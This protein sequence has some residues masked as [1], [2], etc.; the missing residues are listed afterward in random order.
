MDQQ[1]KRLYQ[2]FRAVASR[3]EAGAL[4]AISEARRTVAPE[5]YSEVMRVLGTIVPR[6]KAIFHRRPSLYRD[7]LYSP[8]FNPLTLLKELAW[9]EVWLRGA[10]S[11]LN[12]FL[13][14]Q[15][16][17]QRLFAAG[18]LDRMS[19]TIEDFIKEHGWSFWAVELKYALLQQLKGTEAL[20]QMSLQLQFAA[21]NRASALF[22][23]ILTDRNDA[24]F[25]FD[26]FQ[27]KCAKSTPNFSQPWVRAYVPYRAL[28]SVGDPERD[29]PLILSSEITSSLFD[30]Y[31]GIVNVLQ[32]VRQVEY[33][34]TYRAGALRLIDALLAYGID[35]PRLR[36]TRV[37]LDP[38]LP[39]SVTFRTQNLVAAES[40][41]ELLHARLTGLDSAS[42]VS[43]STAPL[44]R[45][46]D[47][48][49]TVCESQ[50]TAAQD[51]IADLLKIG[52]NF[53]SLP[54]GEL[55]AGKALNS[56]NDLTGHSIVSQ[57]ADL[58][59]DGFTVDELLSNDDKTIERLVRQASLSSPGEQQALCA[60]LVAAMDG[61]PIETLD[62]RPCPA[63]LWLARWLMMSSR[64]EDAITLT[65]S[66]RAAGK[67]WR[68][69][70]TKIRLLID[71]ASGNL[72]R[73]IEEAADVLIQEP[74]YAYELPLA[75]MFVSRR[76]SDFRQLDHVLTGL[77]AHFAQGPSPNAD[78][79]FICRMACRAFY[80]E[81][82]GRDLEQTWLDTPVE[83]RQYLIAFLRDAWVE[84]NL[85]LLESIKSTQEMRQERIRVLQFLLVWD[86]GRAPEY[87]VEIRALTLD[88]TLWRGIR[89]INETRMFVNEAA[90]SRWA[91]KELLPDF[92]RWRQLA[93]ST[94][95]ERLSGD[96][97]AQYLV[98]ADIAALLKALPKAEATEGNTLLLGMLNRLMSTFM[99]NPTDGLDCYLSS[100]IRHGTL[101]GTLLGPM[102]EK[103]LLVIG[104]VAERG[105]LAEWKPALS[106][107]EDQLSSVV[108]S[109]ATFAEKAQ[110]QIRAIV[111]T[112]I[113]IRGPD[114]PDG[115]FP[116]SL[117]PR[118]I[119][120][121]VAVY[122]PD[123][124]FS[125]FLGTSYTA[126]WYILGAAGKDLANFFRSSVKSDLQVGFNQLLEDLRKSGPAA[127]PLIT[128]VQAAATTTQAQCEVVADWFVPNAAVERQTY[129]LSV[130]IEIAKRATQNVYRH[131][132]SDVHIERDETPPIAISTQGLIH[133]TDC[134]FVVCANAWLYS[135]LGGELDV[136]SVDI[137]FD[138]ETQLLTLNVA[139]RMSRGTRDRLLLGDL[140]RLREKYL[141]DLPIDLVPKEGGS[142]F[143]KLARLVASV[144]RTICPKPL[145]F[146][147]D[148]NER[149]YVH[150]VIRLMERDGAFDVFV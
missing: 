125:F 40:P 109:L 58:V 21:K 145:D 70:A 104:E 82:P 97:V 108:K 117:D 10:T 144:D 62:L 100:R 63:T 24:A 128:A 116:A 69:H 20:K 136:I 1:T 6:F 31:A 79:R 74:R 146:G 135:G 123:V 38:E 132:A 129:D 122:K 28:S 39:D 133:L 75:P 65:T 48:Q 46:V 76:W 71:T 115:A 98:D 127:L 8:R 96:I 16:E 32:T 2:I 26:S 95:S 12:E 19:A 87:A 91:E 106:M 42:L 52:L 43:D 35:D 112:R 103:N 33:R 7:L 124:S 78:T 99:R 36:K 110:A 118:R 88:E 141:R 119:A 92:D 143:A 90:I 3:N 93:S 150:I 85:A 134:L 47:T 51:E 84:D 68:R 29:Y 57:G 140:D 60:T 77:V 72:K 131:F 22:A 113:R 120:L 83:T 121:I 130:A 147:I 27:S 5:S 114:Y 126:F 45:H 25:S 41:L 89:Q 18:E 49:I 50:G 81:G 142:G 111:D 37:A 80:S 59:L 56:S 13:A 54:I 107:S 139:N 17:L 138:R 64:H 61:V 102:E 23:V 94:V 30:Y 11:P 4:V 67:Q 149:W 53:K 86:P 9:A 66:L 44:V 105:F 73:A 101:R 14:V 34:T 15:R 55:I 148:A 137:R